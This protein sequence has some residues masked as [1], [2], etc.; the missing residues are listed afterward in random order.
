MIKI[1]Y[2][3]LCVVICSV[4][5]A[6]YFNSCSDSEGDGFTSGGFD[7]KSVYC[8]S[9]YYDGWD[10]DYEACTS[11]ELKRKDVKGNI[12]FAC[13]RMTQGYY[14]AMISTTDKN[15]DQLYTVFTI[16]PDFNVVGF[17][18]PTDYYFSYR[19]A[20]G[21][22]SLRNAEDFVNDIPD[23]VEPEKKIKA[24]ASSNVKEFHKQIA[25]ALLDFYPVSHPYSP[26]DFLD[27]R[28]TL[29]CVVNDEVKDK[30]EAE[31]DY[32][33]GST[34]I[35]NYEIDDRLDEELADARKATTKCVEPLFEGLEIAGGEMIAHLSFAE[36]GNV[37]DNDFDDLRCGVCFV[38]RY[39]MSNIP[40]FYAD[41]KP[42]SR[43][44]C[45]LRWNEFPKAG[46][47]KAIPYIINASHVY[48]DSTRFN[49]EMAS[50]LDNGSYVEIIPDNDLS[51]ISVSNDEIIPDPDYVDSYIIRIKGHGRVELDDDHN[52][53]TIGFLCMDDLHEQCGPFFPSYVSD[54]VGFRVCDSIFTEPDADFETTIRVS[55]NDMIYNSD[56]TE[57]HVNLMLF[58]VCGY[59][60]FGQ[61]HKIRWSA[62]LP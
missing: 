2:F 5:T 31:F 48:D 30:S 18:T 32:N 39:D 56:Y 19:S 28:A 42:I 44:E 45:D 6:F 14:R 35:L 16:D 53:W 62:K 43:Y 12:N 8:K 49:K 11:R 20:N 29:R 54:Y 57:V 33:F 52:E 9:F 10:W 46:S 36:G 7:S 21:D 59:R 4:F 23:Y 50:F 47:Y 58:I 40:V 15:M 41:P 26:V 61:Y 24:V 17:L 13:K 3:K 1:P 25:Q 60:G 51:I 27:W 22:Y 37:S 55:K 34:A 38:E